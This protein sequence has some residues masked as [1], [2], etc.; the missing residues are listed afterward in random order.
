[1]FKGIVWSLSITAVQQVKGTLKILVPS[2][3]VQNDN[4][5]NNRNKSLPKHHHI[6]SH[7][8]VNENNAHE[9]PKVSIVSR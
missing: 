9:I 5:N 8:V 6:H 3:D 1:M 7:I 4:K 2:D